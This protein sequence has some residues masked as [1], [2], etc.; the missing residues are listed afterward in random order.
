[1]ISKPNPDQKL[2]SSILRSLVF[3]LFVA[4]FSHPTLAAEATHHFEL[5]KP[6]AIYAGESVEFTVNAMDQE[7]QKI[8]SAQHSLNVLITNREV[9]VALD[10]NMREGTAKFS[11]KFESDVSYLLWIKD[12]VDS[13][14]RK[15]DAVRV[16][17][18]EMKMAE[19][20]KP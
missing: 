1:M 16:L 5:I 10:L 14:L 19:E 18:A 4:G 3:S 7:N 9:T 2:R 13:R 6:D 17:P 8:S 20:T 12:S 11:H 15:S